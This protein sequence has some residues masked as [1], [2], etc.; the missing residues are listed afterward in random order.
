MQK[1]PYT[2]RNPSVRALRHA[3]A[4]DERRRMF[5]LNRWN[6][7]QRFDYERLTARKDSPSQD[8]HQVWFA[9]SHGDVGGG[10]P[11]AESGL[12]QFPLRWIIREAEIH[13][14]SIDRTAFD[15]LALGLLQTGS[16]QK[17]S[18]PDETA[19]LHRSLRGLWQVLEFLPKNSRWREWE[20]RSLLGFYLPRGEPRLIPRDAMVDPSVY[21]RM[22]R[23]PDYRPVN[24]PPQIGPDQPSRF[25]RSGS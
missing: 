19:P 6:A 10:Y 5:R 11:E 16:N 8:L 4:I 23:V 3:I 1:L 7:A 13:G 20:G 25:D 2:R 21:E 15:Q 12:S 22:R 24:V 17:Y 14:L 9:G 18:A